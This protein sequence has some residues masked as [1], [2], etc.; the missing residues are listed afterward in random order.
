MAGGVVAQSMC[1]D[2]GALPGGF[3]G[4]SCATAAR[5]VEAGSV[6]A[7]RKEREALERSLA[8]VLDRLDGIV[9]RLE[10][11]ERKNVIEAHVVDPKKGARTR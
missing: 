9:D 7:F 8:L 6:V 10:R 3:H 5:L 4:Q 1:K 2:C 11:L